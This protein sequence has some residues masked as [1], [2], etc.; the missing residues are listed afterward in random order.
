MSPRLAPA[1]LAAA[2]VVLTLPAPGCRPAANPQAARAQLDRM[3]AQGRLDDVSETNFVY[4]AFMSDLAAVR[5]YL[6][7]G[8]SP[9]LTNR[10]GRT[11]L[12]G[13]AGA[14]PGSPW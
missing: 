11:P 4:C 12:I 14:E 7:S 1:L 10:Y 3:R 5:L 8:M 13:A 6:D 9:N 2:A